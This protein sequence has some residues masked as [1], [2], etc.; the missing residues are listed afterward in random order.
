MMKTYKYD[1]HVHTKEG[2]ACADISGSRQAR[3]YKELGYDGI[4]ITD[5]FYNGN[6]AVSRKL[7]WEQWVNGF[8]KGYEEAYEEGKRIGISV[9]FG[10]EESIK[11][12]DFLI[13][14]LNKDWL[15]KNRDILGMDISEHYNKIKNDGGFIVHAH[16]F[17]KRYLLEDVRPTPEFEDA[18]EINNGGNREAIYNKLAGEYAMQWHKPVTGG[19]DAHHK[20]D[21]HIG[22][23][24]DSPI[25]NIKEYC[26]VVREGKITKILD[27]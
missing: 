20:K 1:T 3:L 9:F 2:S 23:V 25:N 5:H 19:S 8:M 17:R 16:P 7:P 10:W 24:L 4:I 6:T 11:G 12:M 13:Y 18:V 27:C 22:I 14:G 21:R 26:D 15:L